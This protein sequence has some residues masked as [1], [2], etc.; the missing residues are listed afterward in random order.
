MEQ[1]SEEWHKARKG[2][3]TASHIHKLMGA[4][5]LGQTGESYILEVVTQSLGVELLEG[6]TYAI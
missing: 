4:R 1:R 6:S 3:F 2:R 5:G